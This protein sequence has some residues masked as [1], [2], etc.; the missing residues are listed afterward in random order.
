MSPAQRR[1]LLVIGAVAGALGVAGAMVARALQDNL[2]YFY[3]PTQL[4]AQAVSSGALVRLGG[5]VEPGSV[6]RE[7]DSMKVRFVVSDATHRIPVEYEGL[8]PD[9]FREARGVVASGR[10]APHG[11]FV[12]R[13][14]LAKHEEDYAAP[15]GAE[16]PR[17]VQE[18][19]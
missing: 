17:W 18:R 7:P 15:A 13:E 10:L 3:T 2:L 6:R 1:R 16:R 19:P 11:V 14:V 5:L 9:L 4:Q 12:A 8:L